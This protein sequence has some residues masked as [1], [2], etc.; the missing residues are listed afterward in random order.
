MNYI[1]KQSKN[2]LS[3]KRLEGLLKLSEIIQWGR[4]QP[5]AFVSRF[6]GIERLCRS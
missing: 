3:Q 6:F 4:R 5:V 1:I 2:V